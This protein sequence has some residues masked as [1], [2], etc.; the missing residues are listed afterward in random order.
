MVSS[1]Y[2]MFCLFQIKTEQ[3]ASLSSY[4]ASKVLFAQANPIDI[5]TWHDFFG[6]TPKVATFSVVAAALVSHLYEGNKVGW[7][8]NCLS[9]RA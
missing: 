2:K 9:F 4:F 6:S 5:S 8:A 1:V 3:G 7:H